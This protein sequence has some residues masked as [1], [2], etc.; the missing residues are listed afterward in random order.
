M[1]AESLAGGVVALVDGVAVFGDA[2][3]LGTVV[4]SCVGLWVAKHVP[5][6]GGDAKPALQFRHVV[7]PNAKEYVSALHGVHPVD[8]HAVLYDPIEQA[9]HVVWL[10]V[11]VYRPGEQ[12]EHANW[13][14]WAENCPGIQLAHADLDRAKVPALHSVQTEEA[15]VLTRP[16]SHRGHRTVPTTEANLPAAHGKHAVTPEASL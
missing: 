10:C 12:L 15:D 7:A 8:N 4:G 6:P 5:E 1:Y 11:S 14:G 13:P 3:G 16:T 2:V 9:R